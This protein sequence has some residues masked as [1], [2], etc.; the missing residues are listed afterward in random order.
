MSL[1]SFGILLDNV[2]LKAN[3]K[4]S[5]VVCAQVWMEVL[6]AVLGAWESRHINGRDC[7]H[8]HVT[9]LKARGEIAVRSGLIQAMF[10]LQDAIRC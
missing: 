3:C 1:W 2:C 9:K 8:F 5:E 4:G 7:N 6:A 10:E